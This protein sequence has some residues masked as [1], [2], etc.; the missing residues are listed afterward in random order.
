L[1]RGEAYLPIRKGQEAAREFQ[2]L[3]DH[4]GIMIGDPVAVLARYGLARAYT[5][6]GDATKLVKNILNFSKY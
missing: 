1:I 4:Q 6:S 2:K 5:L 3:L